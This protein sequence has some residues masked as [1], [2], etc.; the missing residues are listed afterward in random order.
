MSNADIRKAHKLLGYVSQGRAVLD[1]EIELLRSF[2]PDLP[3]QKTLEELRKEVYAA[4]LGA[5]GNTWDYDGHELETWL[6]ELYTQLKGLSDAEPAK[7]AHPEFLETEADYENAPEG[8]IVA[9][10]D[11]SP[12]MKYENVWPAYVNSIARNYDLSGTR[13]RVLRWGWGDK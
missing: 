10:G 13:R 9:I 2:L 6:D 5:G 4:W 8:T 1:E 11:E 7:P 3:K 12:R